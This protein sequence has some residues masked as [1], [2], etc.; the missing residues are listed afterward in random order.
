MHGINE[1][2][3]MSLLDK[4][5]VQ[6]STN[7]RCENRGDRIRMVRGW[8]EFFKASCVKVGESIMVKLIWEG[9]KRCVLKF[10]SKV[11]QET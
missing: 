6:W 1:E 5:G 9:D 7:L 2:T 4:H 3:K 10:C 8:K 11:K